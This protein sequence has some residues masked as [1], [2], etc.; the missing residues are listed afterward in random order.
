M[1]TMMTRE[2]LVEIGAKA[3]LEDAGIT[4]WDERSDDMKEICRKRVR[5][6]LKAWDDLGY[7]IRRLN[8]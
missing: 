6:V 8:D 1:N 2:E 3:F 5:A 7:V 4:P